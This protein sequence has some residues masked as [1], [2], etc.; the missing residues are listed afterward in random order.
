[1][2]ENGCPVVRDAR[3]LDVTFVATRVHWNLL[4][5]FDVAVKVAVDP[6]QLVVTGAA[7]S[8]LPPPDPVCWVHVLVVA[9]AYKTAV[10]VAS[11]LKN[12][13]PTVQVPGREVP[14][15][16]GDVLAAPL[17]SCLPVKAFVSPNVATV[18][19]EA[20]KVMITPSVPSRV[21]VLATVN[22]FPLERVRVPVVVVIVSP[23]IVP[24]RISPLGR[25]KVQV[26]VVVI[27]QVPVTAIWL[28]VPARIT[29]V[30]VP[31]LDCSV[32]V[33]VEVQP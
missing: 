14:T 22:V 1:V 32:Q 19:L 31:E 2:I 30:N 10:L 24:G 12:R 16:A 7:A 28:L 27:V 13:S 11:D 23:L 29:L 5:V 8:P 33:L 15:L 20:G 21:S 17:A 3:V 25:E 9:Q 4:N 26:P 18:A 6:E